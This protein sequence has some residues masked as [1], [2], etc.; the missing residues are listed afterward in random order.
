MLKPGEE[1]KLVIDWKA[2]AAPDRAFRHGG[3]VYTND[4]ENAEVKFT[5]EGAID[6]PVEVLPNQW[7]V[8]NIS[9]DRTGTFR[10]AIGSRLTDQL[11]VESV[12]SP[13]GKVSVRVDPMRVEELA[14]EKWAKGFSLDVEIA[15]DIPVGKFEEDIRINIKG[16]DQVPFVTAR[17]TAQQVRQFH[18]AATGWRDVYPGQNGSAVRSVSGVGRAES[19]TSADR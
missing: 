2:G 9:L 12:E 16:V 5:V 17:L 13:S 19:P 14:T 15:A 3:P 18:S 1:T 7:S 11:E 10:A 8:G 4:P 6:M